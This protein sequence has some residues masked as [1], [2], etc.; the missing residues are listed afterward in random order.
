MTAASLTMGKFI[1]AIVIAII[2]SS[3]I[4]IGVST[5]LMTGPQ[6]EKGIRDHKDLRDQK[7]I[8]ATL[9]QQEQMEQLDHKEQ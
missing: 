4:S 7:A 5:Q 1:A 9:D 6:G 8:L 3:A 2:A